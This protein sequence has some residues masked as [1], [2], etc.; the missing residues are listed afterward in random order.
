[1]ASEKD[2]RGEQH[3]SGRCRVCDERF[4]WMTDEEYR[5]KVSRH[6]WDNHRDQPIDKPLVVRDD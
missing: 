4:V 1:V 5:S 2:G 6:I 3:R